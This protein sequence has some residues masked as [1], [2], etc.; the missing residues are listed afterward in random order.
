MKKKQ[1]RIRCWVDIDGV[2]FFGPGPAQLLQ[3]IDETG[4]I[5]KAAKEMKMSYKKAWDIV[6]QLNQRGQKPYVISHKGGEKGGGA[7]LTLTG[8][9]VVSAYYSLTE[10]I[11]GVVKK[12]ISLLKVI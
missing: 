3:L 9:K 7:E 6:V 11:N 10:K 1:I 5:S 4:S 12:D 2:K 8:R